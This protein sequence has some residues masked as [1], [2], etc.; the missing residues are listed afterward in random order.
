MAR[1]SASVLLRLPFCAEATQGALAALAREQVAAAAP[2]LN[3]ILARTRARTRTRTLAR[4]LT[5]TLAL[6][7]ALALALVLA[8]TLTL[9][10]SRWPRPQ[11]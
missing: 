5:L 6:T 2:T 9:T 7:L 1:P 3:L 11:R 8:R 4:T 10:L